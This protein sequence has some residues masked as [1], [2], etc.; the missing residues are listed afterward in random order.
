MISLLRVRVDASEPE[1][2]KTPEP[3]W[4]KRPGDREEE[5]VFPSF[6]AVEE[7]VPRWGITFA[8]K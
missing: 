7:A 4:G 6:T 3:F 1:P 5:E 2:K 8:F